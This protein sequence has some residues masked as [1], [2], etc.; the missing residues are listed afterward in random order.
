LQHDRNVRQVLAA[1]FAA[2]DL[3]LDAIESDSHKDVG[4]LFLG[5]AVSFDA[6]SNNSWISGINVHLADVYRHLR[7][8]GS[9]VKHF[10]RL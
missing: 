3:R 10:V 9:F 6:H 1:V 4:V 2:Q 5:F 8:G 7:Y